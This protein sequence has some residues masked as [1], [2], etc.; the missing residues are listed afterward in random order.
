MFLPGSLGS[1][2]ENFDGRRNETCFLGLWHFS[3]WTFRPIIEEGLPRAPRM[4]DLLGLVEEQD[5]QE[6][7][8]RVQRQGDVHRAGHE[9]RDTVAPPGHAARRAPRAEVD[10]GVRDALDALHGGAGSPL[11]H[12]LLHSGTVPSRA[13]LL[14][15]GT[16]FL[17]NS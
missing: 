8:L 1:R 13:A 7:A 3:L 6:E 10:P 15:V 16:V 12:P 17:R 9:G 2:G 4:G 5:Q 11:Q 14:L